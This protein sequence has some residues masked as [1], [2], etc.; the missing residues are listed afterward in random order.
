MDRPYPID[1]MNILFDVIIVYAQYVYNKQEEIIDMGKSIFS[2]S[3]IRYTM[4]RGGHI[5]VYMNIIAL[6]NIR[7]TVVSIMSF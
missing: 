5:D 7:S 1:L 3:H 2:L 4:K 6:T